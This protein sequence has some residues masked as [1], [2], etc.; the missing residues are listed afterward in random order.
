MKKF[1]LLPFL[2]ISPLFALP[3]GNP[4]DANL[5]LNG[6]F[7]NDCEAYCCDPCDPCFNWCDAW[8]VRLGFYGDY[9]FNRHMELKGGGKKDIDDFEIYTNAAY[10]ALNICDRVDIFTT[11]GATNFNLT[12]NPKVFGVISSLRLKLETETSFS[13]S[14]GGRATI[15]SCDCFYF[16]IEGQ[17]FATQPDVEVVEV[18]GF[19]PSYPDDDITLKYREWQVGL[20]AAYFFRVGCSGVSAIPYLGLKWAGSSADFNNGVPSPIT[21]L[22]LYDLENKKRWGW[23]LGMTLLFCDA[24]G[25]T[26][27]GRWADEKAVHV[28]GQLRF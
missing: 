9:V 19:I 13:W 24:L 23:G 14:I 8:S 10:L 22:T 28:N 3:I 20:G 18:A 26:V 25:V 16:G 5:Y 6:I 7:R 21:G 17:Y 15:W 12:A 27:E 1:L 11:L 2:L 4:M